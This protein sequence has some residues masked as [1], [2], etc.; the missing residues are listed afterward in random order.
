MD[1][2]KLNALRSQLR[3]EMLHSL[4][5]MFVNR[6]PDNE[7]LVANPAELCGE[8]RPLVFYDV[9]RAL[10]VLGICIFSV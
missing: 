2:E 6:G 7:L 1:P 4:R 5:V 10:K 8:G 3:Q 9:T